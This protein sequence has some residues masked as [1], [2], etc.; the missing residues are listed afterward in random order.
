MRHPWITLA[1]IL[2]DLAMLL[3]IWVQVDSP[4]RAHFLRVCG[5][6]CDR[7][8]RGRALRYERRRQ[9]AMQ[10]GGSIALER[11]IEDSAKRRGLQ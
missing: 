1:T 7:C 4:S 10:R 2:F 8:R 9:A 6:S 11:A 5:S 3:A